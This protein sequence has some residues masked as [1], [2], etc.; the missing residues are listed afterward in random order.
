M[1][2][3]NVYVLLLINVFVW[4]GCQKQAPTISKDE[5]TLSG[6][7]PGGGTTPPP[8]VPPLNCLSPVATISSFL[9]RREVPF[10]DGPFGSAS[11]SFTQDIALHNSGYF[12]IIESYTRIRK[13]DP[14]ANTITTLYTFPSTTA[15]PTTTERP[16]KIATD[17]SGNIYVS[18]S[19]HVIRKFNN[20]GYLL[21]TYGTVGMAGFLDGSTARFNYPMGLAVDAAGRIYVADRLNYRIR[22]ISTTGIV[23]TLAGGAFGAGISPSPDGPATSANF[24][25][26]NHIVVSQD[27]STVYFNDFFA[28]RR[29][30]GGQIT[31]IA[32][33]LYPRYYEHVDGYLGVS[34]F[35]VITC[36]TM[37]SWGR[38]YVIDGASGND[39]LSR[40][41]VPNPLFGWHVK[42]L[43]TGLIG[44]NGASVNGNGSI[45]YLADRSG[46]ISRA[47]VSCP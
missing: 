12:Y 17:A 21:A 22:M 18:T 25:S 14:I 30:Y 45:L 40:I 13:V 1:K 39:K 26:L 44:D 23:T 33:K 10:S 11:L 27:G 5:E 32:G 37:D 4:S 16:Y 28:I 46:T 9:T 7:A 43:A 20:L 19:A 38:L 2:F 35:D 42:T 36:L 29:L 15:F 31:T 24:R 47:T 3:K 34:Q 41:A 6:P 8:V